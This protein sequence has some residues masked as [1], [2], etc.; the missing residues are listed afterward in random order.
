MVFS[1]IIFIFFF[2]PVCIVGYYGVFNKSIKMK[3]RWLLACSLF[4]YAWGGVQHAALMVLSIIVN[5][6]MAV[7]ISKTNHKKEY[8]LIGIAYNISI[9]IVF[10]YLGFIL[11]NIN[12]LFNAKAVVPEIALPIGIS[13]FTFQSMSYLVDIYIGNG[14]AL[15][16][17]LDVGLYISLFPQLIAGPIVRYNTIQSQINTRTESVEM[18]YSGIKR[19][20]YGLGKK[21]VIANTVAI[22]AKY[23]FEGHFADSLGFAWLGAVAYTL[24]I[25]FDFSGYSD[26]AIG[27][28]RMFGFR[29][30]E[31]F[32]APYCSTSV[33]E[34][35][36][37]WHISMGTWF[38][39]YV[40]FPLGGSRCS[41]FRN[42][43]NLSIV[44]ILTGLWHGANWNFIVWGILHLVV[45]IVEK[46]LCTGR[47]PGGDKE[48]V[49]LQVLKYLYTMFFVVI[50]W[51]LFNSSSL[52]EATLF[53]KA[54]FNFSGP[55]IDNFGA[56]LIKEYIVVITLAVLIIVLEIKKQNVR[57]I[58]ANKAAL[59]A[60]GVALVFLLS[61]C[62]L[63][64]GS[65]NPFIY[66]NF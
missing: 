9:L 44:W 17:P 30:L 42:I 65:Y 25:Y 23:A 10:K 13:F 40:Y 16:D 8:L 47:K 7:L 27:L 62:Y 2:L 6:Y 28:A 29:L 64:K 32:D 21:A 14:N 50:G 57:S 5:W 19:F 52:A 55:I 33:T 48:N 11:N 41:R 45:I 58:F 39:D 24:Q 4:F 53:L 31:N 54:M 1:S 26:M 59:E 3:N 22:V 12:A 15:D 37:R 51:V 34:F 38:R 36:R 20:V 56:V 63:I 66:F 46:Y 49:V 35:W 18:F 60:I 43:I 61:V